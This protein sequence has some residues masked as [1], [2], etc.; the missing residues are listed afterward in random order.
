MRKR[1]YENAMT[2]VELLLVVLLM[3]TLT[4]AAAVHFSRVSRHVRLT[5][6]ADGM[7][8]FLKYAQSRAVLTGEPLAVEVDER[9]STC[10]LIRTGEADGPIEE[11]KKFEELLSHKLPENV[12]FDFSE[13]EIV[14]GSDGQIGRVR[15]RMCSGNDC[16]VV[17]TEEQRGVVDVAFENNGAPDG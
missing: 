7:V 11:Q 12:T 16:A 14:F 1:F 2:L 13:P 10:R 5:G 15:I 4:A 17:S 3:G 9:S 8:D 6:A